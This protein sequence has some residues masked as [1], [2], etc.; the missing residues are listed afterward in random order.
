MSTLELAG[1]WSSQRIHKKMIRSL[2]RTRTTFFDENPSGRL[3]NRVMGEFAAIRLGGP[4]QLADALHSSTEL[5]CMMIIVALVNPLPAL[6][7]IPILC[8]YLYFQT[9]YAPMLGHLR[10]LISQADGDVLHRETDLIEGRNIYRQYNREDHLLSRV[11]DSYKRKLNLQLFRGKLQSWGGLWRGAASA[12][13]SISVYGFVIAGI[14]NESLSLALAGVI[15]TVLFGLEKNI[16]S[17]SLSTTSLSRTTAHIR[18]IYE[19]IDLPNEMDEEK[20][21]KKGR[22]NEAPQAGDIEFCHF[23]MSYRKDSA[24]ILEN[25]SLTIPLGKH[26]GIVGRTGSGKSSLI[27]SLLRMVYVNSGDIKIAGRSIYDYDTENYRQLFGVVPQDPYLFKGSVR[28]NLTGSNEAIVDSKLQTILNKLG[29]S[30]DLDEQVQE[31]GKN[32]SLGQRQLMSLGRILASNRQIIILDEPTSSID[33]HSDTQIQRIIKEEFVGCTVITVAHRTG[34]LKD[35]D[36]I[37]EIDNGAA[38]EITLEQFT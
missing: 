7:I 14:Y 10:E 12:V 20:D 2:L 16:L 19:F 24:P 11:H 30:V 27:Q 28:F 37:F 33:I 22:V 1:L 36:M 31:G 8:F 34:T 5:F 17:V 26:V 15:I 9:R 18:R 6:G 29:L 38:K 13:F 23:S 4:M 21:I 3:I 25:L 35:A 32:L